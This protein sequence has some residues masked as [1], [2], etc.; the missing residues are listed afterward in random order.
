[1]D[2]RLTLAGRALIALFAIE[3]SGLALALASFKLSIDPATLWRGRFGVAAALCLVGVATSTAVF[4]T[5]AF[6]AGKRAVALA[7]LANLVPLM[8]TLV[9][10]E[11]LLRAWEH[12]DARGTSIAGVPIPMS[13]DTLVER[14]RRVVAELDSTYHVYDPDLGWIVG[15]SR[16]GNNGLYYSSTEGLRSPRLGM[17]YA[18][19]PASKR[20]ALIGDSNAFSL[21]VSWSDSIARH[22]GDRLGKDVLVLNFGVDGYGIDQTYVRYLRDV[23]PWRPDVVVF[24]FVQHDFLRAMAVYPFVSFGWVGYLVKPRFDLEGDTLRIVNAP[25]PAPDQI[26]GAKA[27]GDLPFVDYDPGYATRDWSWSYD[28]GPYLLRLVMSRFPRYPLRRRL[29]AIDLPSLNVRLVAALHAAIESDGATPV[30]VY[31]P[32]GLHDEVLSENVIGALTTP[33]L[34]MTECVSRV[35]APAR[36]TPS[37]HHYTG[38]GNA[39]IAACIEPAVRC[40]LDRAVCPSR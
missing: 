31:L 5:C 16:Q 18:D 6:A 1:M 4:V 23:R 25:L 34:D 27:V 9:S 33:F 15:K 14:N 7:L 13:W 20:V 10:A 24:V 35:P 26:L 2:P 38:A 39:A 29:G 22:L 17:T 28:R 11:L 30:F 36:R 19:D 32:S 40:G 21:E 12:R 8:V 37:G 3:A